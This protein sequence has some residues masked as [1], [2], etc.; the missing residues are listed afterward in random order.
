MFSLL[1]KNVTKH[2]KPLW[3]RDR[4]R[5]RDRETDRDKHFQ[6]DLKVWEYSLAMGLV[7]LKDN[8]KETQQMLIL[9]Y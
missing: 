5:Q 8:K 7:N 4:E 6:I 3:Q 9:R 2:N 1:I